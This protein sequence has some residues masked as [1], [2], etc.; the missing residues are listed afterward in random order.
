MPETIQRSF[1]GGE[2]APSLR[3][4]ADLSKYTSGL[5]LCKNMFPRSQGGVYSRPGTKFIGELDDS[6]RRGRLIPFSFNTDQ[7]YILVFEHL[8][9]RVIRDGGYVLSG[10]SAIYEIATPYTESEIPR[11]GFTQSADVMTIVHPSHDPRNLSRTADNAWSLDVIDYTPT[12]I[13]PDWVTTVTKDISNITQANPAVVTTSTNHGLTTDDLVYISGVAGMTEINDRTFG[14]V[15]VDVNTFILKNENSTAHSAYVLNGTVVHGGLTSFGNGAGDFDKTYSYV[16]TTVDESGSESIASTVRTITT[17]S[18]STTAGVRLNWQAVT[19]ASYYR[20]YKDPSNGTGIYG[21][22]G[23]SETTQFDDYNV[24]PI[25]S[26]APPQDRDPFSGVNN[27]PA[28]V[29]YYQQRQI[30]A[31][32]N[33]ERQTVYTTQ[34]GNFKSLRTSTPTRSDDAVTFTISAKE[35]NE[36]RHIVE[37]DSM[38]LLTSGG[39]W[40]MTEGQDEVLTPSTVGVRKQSNNGA[41]WVPPAIVNDTVIYIQEKGARVRDLNYE[42]VNDRFRGNDLSIMAEHLFEDY[43][44]EEMTYSSEPYGILWCVRNDGVLLGLTYQREHQVWAWHQHDTNGI[45]ESVASVTEDGRDAVY[46]IV[47]RTINGGTKRYVERFEKRTVS[48][49]SNVFCVDSGLTYSGSAATVITGLDHLEGHA[50]SVVADGNVV[51]NLTVSSG[52]ITLPRASENVT[53]GLSY[54]PVIETLDVDVTSTAESLKAKEVSI[55]K[56]TLEVEKSRGGWVGPKMDDDSTGDMFEIKPRF[57]SDQYNSIALKTFK[58]E[59]IIH[60]QWSLG[61]GIRIEQRDP[62][63][64][65]ILAIVP[66]VNIG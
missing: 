43:E 63:P 32:T 60:P 58:Q 7:T 52:S 55:T 31:N 49:S 19:G 3:S 44:I 28:T 9:I 47:N 5:S 53:V 29:N 25:S 26:D 2:I 16:I 36:I 30:F 27:K 37:I 11:L 56:V 65:A 62:L 22:I 51:R 14:I 23:N 57:D 1:T 33:N 34:V 66:E 35:V 48:D 15:V 50:V 59:V 24:A 64:L 21:W 61:G 13:A 39:E 54:T 38:I 41:S 6:S 17:P 42:F 18:L 12:I 4:R 20:I 45:F 10:G 8:K 40:R 46:V